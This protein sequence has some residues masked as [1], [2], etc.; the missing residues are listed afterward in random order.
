[1]AIEECIERNWND[2]LSKG[3]VESGNNF[4]T[5]FADDT[6]LKFSLLSSLHECDYRKID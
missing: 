6:E 5:Q 3:F 4:I 2:W 1:M